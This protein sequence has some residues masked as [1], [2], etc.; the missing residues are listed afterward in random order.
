MLLELSNSY[1]KSSGLVN[2]MLG[3]S[4]LKMLQRCATIDDAQKDKSANRLLKIKD[5]ISIRTEGK[6]VLIKLADIIFI[7]AA[8]NY[9]EIFTKAQ[10]YLIRDTLSN[11]ENR[12]PDALFIRIHRSVII[13]AD[14]IAEVMTWYN[15]ELKIVLSSG[16]GLVVSR[17]FR[18]NIE[19]LLET[20]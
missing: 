12:L 5:R 4:D 1:S 10:K 16:D 18:T 7:K 6:I 17:N 20:M 11:M 15:G 14:C 2:S 9:V 19:S 3:V 13:N 8:G